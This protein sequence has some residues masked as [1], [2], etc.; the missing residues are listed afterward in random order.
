[1]TDINFDKK[2]RHPPDFPTWD[3]LLVNVYISYIVFLPLYPYFSFWTNPVNF[4]I[5]GVPKKANKSY[6][7]K[8]NKENN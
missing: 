2:N 4:D 3:R 6:D 8:K 1:M 7:D 5:D